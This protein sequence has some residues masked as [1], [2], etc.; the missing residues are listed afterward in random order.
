MS[1]AYL[2]DSSSVVHHVGLVRSKESS[3]PSR[4]AIL[5]HGSSKLVSKPSELALGRGGATA[6]PAKPSVQTRFLL[7]AMDERDRLVQGNWDRMFESMEAMTGRLKEVERGQ[8]QLLMHSKLVAVVVEQAATERN[9]LYRKLEETGRE[10][11]QLRL[12]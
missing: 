3:R 8:Q 7:E 10:V 6:P 2:E 11:S 9:D 5:S 4:S 12:E 1:L